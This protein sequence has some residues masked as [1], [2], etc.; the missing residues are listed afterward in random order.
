MPMVLITCQVDDVDEWEEQFRTHGA[1]FREQTISRVDIGVLE[2]NHVALVCQ[3]D[4]LDTCM[5]ILDSPEAAEAMENDGVR[6][7]TVKVFVVD[8]RFDP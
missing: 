7:E 1:L 2:D 6:R 3:V 4:D 8:R 5:K